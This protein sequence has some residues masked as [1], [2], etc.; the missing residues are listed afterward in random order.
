MKL[1]VVHIVVWHEIFTANECFS[2]QADIQ[3]PLLTA[4]KNLCNNYNE[5]RKLI[6]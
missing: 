4:T 2:M 1:I 5:T 3:T 6:G